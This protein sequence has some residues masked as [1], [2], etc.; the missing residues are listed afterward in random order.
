MRIRKER[1]ESNLRVTELQIAISEA[2]SKNEGVYVEEILLALQ[3]EQS[4]WINI[5]RNDEVPSVEKEDDEEAD[6]GSTT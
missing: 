5:L 3:N 1:V 2:I 6:E 4:H